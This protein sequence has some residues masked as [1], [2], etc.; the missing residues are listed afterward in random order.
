MSGPRG[1]VPFWANGPY[2]LDRWEHDVVV[3]M[4]PNPGYW[5]V[6]NLDVKKAYLPIVPADASVLTFEHGEGEQ[7]LD[8][9]NIPAS[10]L[11]RYQ[12]DPELSKQLKQYVYPGIWMLVPSNGQEPFQNDEVGLKVRQALSHAVD[13]S[14]IVELTNGLAI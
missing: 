10:D 7:R 13:R 14:R 8:W 4:S 3:E 5:N 9:V 6:E 12:E 2:L 11:T 1:S